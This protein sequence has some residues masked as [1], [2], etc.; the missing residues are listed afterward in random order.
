M[1]GKDNNISYTVS[2]GIWDS[3]FAVPSDVVDRHMK[4]AGAAQLKVARPGTSP[5]PC[6]LR[7][8]KSVTFRRLQ[9]ATRLEP[10]RK[11]KRPSR[12]KR[13]AIHSTNA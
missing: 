8:K 5:N 1:N 9:S 11:K 6:R 3:V 12:R 10:R 13:Y 4:L 7:S 2:I